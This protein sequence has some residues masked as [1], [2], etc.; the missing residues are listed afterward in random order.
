MAI[1]HFYVACVLAQVLLIVY[2]AVSDCEDLPEFL[3]FQS[4]YD[5]KTALQNARLLEVVPN[6][7][8]GGKWRVQ[9]SCEQVFR[10]K[11]EV[12]SEWPP[13]TMEEIEYLN[14]QY[15][16]DLT[17][18]DPNVKLNEYYCKNKANHGTAALWTEEYV[19][20]LS[21]ERSMCGQYE[22]SQCDTTFRKYEA[23]IRDKHGIVLGTQVPW[24]EGALVGAGARKVTTV[25]YMEIVSLHPRVETITPAA[26]ASKFLEGTMEPV[27]FIFTFSSVEHDGLGRYG[28]P[29]N[30][31]GDFETI[32]KMHCLLKP[33]GLLFFAVPVGQDEIQYNAHRIYGYRRL[34][35]VL[36]MGFRVVDV[37]NDRPFR[38][39]AY[40]KWEAQPI[41]V[42]QKE[43]TF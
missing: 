14:R 33:G 28:D 31:F 9:F 27:D 38:L 20:A 29:L 18:H 25:E 40:N 22:V 39:D 15:L 30:A 6:P 4:T 41:F 10:A 3:Q 21:K 42:L 12:E 19:T 35:V 5:V 13:P 37:I 36:S 17:L 1:A 7:S 2:A 16:Q 26:V 24:A 43:L 23:F 11:E 8:T 34:S 32:A